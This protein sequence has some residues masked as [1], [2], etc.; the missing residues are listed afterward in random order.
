MSLSLLEHTF[1]YNICLLLFCDFSD[2]QQFL[3]YQPNEYSSLI[4][5][6]ENGKATTYDDEN[7]GHT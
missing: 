3:Q 1:P 7:Q 2:G 6:I 5:T 4:L